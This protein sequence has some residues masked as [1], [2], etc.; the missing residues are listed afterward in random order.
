MPEFKKIFGTAPKPR[1]PKATLK[2]KLKAA[3]KLKIPK[4]ARPKAVRP[5]KALPKAV[6]KS[7]KKKGG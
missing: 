4:P 2:P 5:K 1:P 6:R 3:K 7:V